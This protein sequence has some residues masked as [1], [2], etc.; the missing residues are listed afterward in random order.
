MTKFEADG[1]AMAP[2]R[3]EDDGR[4]RR[5]TDGHGWTRMWAG[6]ERRKKRGW[7]AEDAEYAEGVAG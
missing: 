2:R 6:R 3:Q 1:T 5:T 4:G 7:T